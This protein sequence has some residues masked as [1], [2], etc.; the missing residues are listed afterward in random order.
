MEFKRQLTHITRRLIAQIECDYSWALIHNVLIAFNQENVS[1][2][3]N[4]AHEIVSGNKE[5]HP[6]FTVLQL[7][8][9]HIIK[10][11]AQGF[12]KLTKDRDIQ[13]YATYSFAYLQNCTTLP[14]ALD[15]FYHMCV[16]FG[17]ELCTQTVQESERFL[18]R[19]VFKTHD[20]LEHI[21]DLKEV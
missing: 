21:E 9:A 3:L 13:E 19:C 16:L 18:D 4:K 1:A 11:V 10:A 17:S 8:S 15:V 14:Q 6:K 20:V 12:G 2:Y 7:C 5:D